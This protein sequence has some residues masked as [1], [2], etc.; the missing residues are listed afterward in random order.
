MVSSSSLTILNFEGIMCG[1]HHINICLN[2]VST[3]KT[4]KYIYSFLTDS[5]L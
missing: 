5:K 4:Q 1:K 2:Y 3:L